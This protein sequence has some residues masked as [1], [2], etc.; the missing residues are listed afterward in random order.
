MAGGFRASNV[1]GSLITNF[2]VRSAAPSAGVNLES[3]A[4]SMAVQ[5]LD[6]GA[7]TV[8]HAAPPEFGGASTRLDCVTSG[9]APLNAGSGR[10]GYFSSPFA[11]FANP[12][13]GNLRLSAPGVVVGAGVPVFSMTDLA[14]TANGPSTRLNLVGAA[15][16]WFGFSG[17]GAVGND[18]A[19]GSSGSAVYE[20]NVFARLSVPDYADLSFFIGGYES[21]TAFLS[22]GPDPTAVPLAGG[23]AFV[24]LTT[25]VNWNS[26]VRLPGSAVPTKVDLGVAAT[27]GTVYLFLI[28]NLVGGS[29]RFSIYSTAG[30]LLGTSTF[31]GYPVGFSQYNYTV[32]AYTATAAGRDID[33]YNGMDAQL[34]SWDS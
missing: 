18:Y 12:C 13:F 7:P 11:D 29:V 3:S 6:T 8:L 21:L 10:F 23:A 16:N 5:R 19:R 33:I 27:P 20:S 28:E 14:N 15:G 26:F 30:A 25:D 32:G 34:N 4:T 31:A 1:R 9:S 22:T 24:K 2:A 17:T